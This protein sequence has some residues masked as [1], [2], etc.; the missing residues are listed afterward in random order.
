[1]DVA[2]WKAWAE[3]EPRRRGQR[4]F[5][6]QAEQAART[7]EQRDDEYEFV[8][9]VGLVSW[10]APDGRKIRR[11][12]LTEQ[13]LPVLDRTGAVRVHRLAGKRCLEDRELFEG[14]PEYRPERGRA[15]KNE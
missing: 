2:R 10:Q 4:D 9:A 5:H 6:A 15:A 3:R 7:I 8:L 11:H 1:A 14:Q 13:L 12:L